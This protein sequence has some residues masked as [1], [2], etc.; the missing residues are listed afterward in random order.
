METIS[1][2]ETRQIEIH[3]LGF[4]FYL[5]EKFLVYTL[6]PMNHAIVSYFHGG[7]SAPMHL[8]MKR[9]NKL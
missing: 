5:Y 4:F 1:N 9:S 3:S 6:G 7:G 8:E 2:I